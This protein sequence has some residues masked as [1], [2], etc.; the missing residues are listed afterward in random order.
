MDAWAAQQMLGMAV[1]E[2]SSYSEHPE[3]AQMPEV[4]LA[5]SCRQVAWDEVVALVSLGIS[6]REHSLPQAAKHVPVG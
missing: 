2:G 1:R 4:S 6:W 3:Q 5:G